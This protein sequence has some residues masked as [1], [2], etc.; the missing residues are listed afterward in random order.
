MEAIKADP[1]DP[2]PPRNLSACYYELGVYTKCITTAKDA[3]SLLGVDLSPADQAH[4]EKLQAR[5]SKAGIHLFK[6]GAAEKKEVRKRILEKLPRYKPSMFTSTEYFTVG[7]DD[8][9]TIFEPDMFKAFAPETKEVSFFLGGVGDAR[10]VLQTF[11]V[12]SE[13]ERLKGSPERKY[14]FTI[15]DISK[16]ALAR[17]MVVWMLLNKLTE[18]DEED[19]REMVLNTVFFIY[20]STLMPRY[21]FEMLGETISNAI[22]TLEKGN[23]PLKWLFLH[24]KDI[25]SYLAALRYWLGE[26]KQ[27]FTSNEIVGK[28]ALKMSIS[29]AA[30]HMRNEGNAFYKNEKRLYIE[31]AV[32]FPS[33]RV[34]QLHDPGFLEMIQ[35]YSTSPRKNSKI[36]KKY[37]GENWHFNTT[38][39][40][41]DWYADLQG[42]HMFDLGFN[43]FEAIDHFAYLEV[44]TK[45]NRPD[46]LFEHMKPFFLEAAKAI[47]YLGERLKVEAILGDYVDVA[48]KIQF[49]LYETVTRP[50][51]FPILYDRIHLSNV[52]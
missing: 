13:S 43:P 11:A 30:G 37:L 25:P 2:I 9:A 20:L 5:I 31:S 10:A 29:E 40:D 47:E 39:M 6:S 7:H 18:L 42:K 27:I 19:E 41:K 17:N 15:N 23:S 22:D 21:A 52:P 16:S 4:F 51:E 50:K 36:F 33:N 34:L 35:K 38:L 8:V 26:G 28:V 45:P 49:G 14:H 3:I 12:I 24:E 44:Q 46:R 48:E 32:L 1:A